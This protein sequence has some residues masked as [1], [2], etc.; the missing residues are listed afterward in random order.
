MSTPTTSRPDHQGLEGL[1]TVE[2]ALAALRCGHPV[3]VLDD[4]DRENEGDV[5]LAASLATPQWVAWTVKHGSGLLCAPLPAAL[6]DSLGLPD[7]V[8]RNEDSLRTAYTVTVDAA[9]GVTTGISAAD[10]ARTARVLADPASGPADLIRPGHVLPLRA[11]PGGVLERRGHTEAAVDLCRLAGLPP[12]AIITELVDLDDP[13]GDMLRGPAVV[14]LGAAH[15]LPVI[16][17]EQLAAHL[18]SATEPPVRDHGQS[19]TSERVPQRQRVVE[20]ARAALPTEH[21]DFTAVAFRDLATGAEHLAVVAEAPRSSSSSSSSVAQG[22]PAPLVRVHSECLTGDAF[23]SL[24]CD[25]G[26]Q[27][28]AALERIGAEGGVLVHVGG[29]EG[30]AI[31]LSAKIAAYA[32]QDAGADTVDA[33]LELGLPVDAREYGGAA[34]V[35]RALGVERVRLLSNNP[36]K[37]IGLVEHGV[38][39]VEQLGLHIGEHDDDGASSTLRGPALS[40]PL[41]EAYLATK[42][43]RMGHTPP[44]PRPPSALSA[45]S[46]EPE[47]SGSALSAA[48]ARR[49]GPGTTTSFATTTTQEEK[50]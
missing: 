20:V 41:R 19:A 17:I 30:R 10:R 25:C 39:V 38:D 14:A 50:A 48:S 33:N 24:R 8:E 26:P 12:V 49:T 7:M 21:G 27:L 32:L 13:D 3:L 23:G 47:G 18:R 1:S 28:R 35:L 9:S 45:A 44:T 5:I 15:G 2:E 4:D 22:A 40:A 34:A 36:S 29:H 46:A 16:T 37:A 6:A 43:A 42:R 31:G 11:R